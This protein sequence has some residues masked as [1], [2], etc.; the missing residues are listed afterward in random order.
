M[1]L[2]LTLAYDGTRYAGWQRQNSARRKPAPALTK[3]GPGAQG[4]RNKRRVTVQ[5]EVERALSIIL[6]EKVQ[7]TGSGRTDAGV[8]ALAQVAHASAIREIPRQRLLRSVNQLLPPDI[9]VLSVGTA[10]GSF[11]ARFDAVRKRYRYRIFTGK[12]VTPFV[13][14]YVFHAPWPLNAAR[15]QREVKALSGTRDF[16]AFVR[17]SSGKKGST[18]RRIIRASLKRKGQELHFEIEGSGFLHTMVRSLAGTLM[19]VGRGRLPEGTIKRLLKSKSRQ[20][21]GITAPARGL[22]LISVTY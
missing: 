11:H 13:R 3:G 9:S 20:G 1:R 19:D 15:M 7:V 10:N 17:A 21:A 6:Q 5:E 4:A 16:K 22:T 14:P 18:R 8:H 12:V 2:K